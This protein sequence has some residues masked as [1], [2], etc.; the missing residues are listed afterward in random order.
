MGCNSGG[1]SRQWRVDIFI[2]CVGGLKRG[3]GELS[4]NLRAAV[5][6]R[7]VVAGTASS[8]PRQEAAPWGRGHGQT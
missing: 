5:G 7:Q 1:M 2:T 6:E 4:A 3:V 8:Q